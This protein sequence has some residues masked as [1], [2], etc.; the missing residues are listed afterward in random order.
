MAVRSRLYTKK[1][2]KL[3]QGFE[4]KELYLFGSAASAN[5][6]ADSNL[7]FVVNFDRVGYAGVFDQFVNFKQR[8]GKIFGRPVDLYH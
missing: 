7:D 8:L 6:T 3:C 2:R 4:V 5:I 1:R